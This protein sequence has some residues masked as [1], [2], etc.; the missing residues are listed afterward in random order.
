L[1]VQQSAGIV[2]AMVIALAG[3]KGGTGKTTTAVC[4]ASEW[5]ARGRRVVLVD[6]DPQ[7]SSRTWAEVAAEANHASPTVIAMGSG[8]HRPDQLPALASSY[9]FAVVDCPPRHGDI[10]R[11]ALMVADLVVIPCGPSGLDAWALGATLDLI[12]EAR[13]V[14]PDLQVVVV[15]TRRV[16][17][18]TL[19]AQARDVLASSQLRVLAAELGHRVA[20]QEA[21]AAGLGVTG[22]APTSAAAAEVRALADELE[23]L[24]LGDTVHDVDV[25]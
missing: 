19:G 8:L 7:G 3:Q 2:A 1:D 22:Y 14:R 20:Y 9:D 18:T 24:A 4:L 6:A 13:I 23:H 15:I 21:L 10:Q 16:A 17:R 11:S 25:A 5:H 12:E